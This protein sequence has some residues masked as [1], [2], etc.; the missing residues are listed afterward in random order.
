MRGYTLIKNQHGY[1]AMHLT[2]FSYVGV[3]LSEW[4]EGCDDFTDRSK[5]LRAAR[6]YCKLIGAA[7]TV[8]C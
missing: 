1:Y 2:G 5:A 3:L 7:L 6:R 8:K 4:G